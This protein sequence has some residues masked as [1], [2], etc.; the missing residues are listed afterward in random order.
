MKMVPPTESCRLVRIGK[1]SI[2]VHIVY[3]DQDGKDQVIDKTIEY[4]VGQANASIALDKMNVLY[5][6]V[7]NPITIAASGG[8]DDKFSFDQRWW[9]FNPKLVLVN[10]SLRLTQLT[11]DCKITVSVEGKV[12]GNITI[13]CSYHSR[14]QLQHRWLSNW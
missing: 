2:P 14:C 6:G 9:W 5:I 7:E 8:G 12:A 13:P 4:T 11:D 10:I 3:K 1:H